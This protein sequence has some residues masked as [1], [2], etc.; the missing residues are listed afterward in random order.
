MANNVP[1][2][3]GGTHCHVANCSWLHL[4]NLTALK[5]VPPL[6]PNP[7]LSGIGVVLGFSIS[8][9]LTIA[10]LMLHYLTVHDFERTNSRGSQYINSI[11]RGILT[12]VRGRIISWKPSKRFEYAMEKSVLILSDLNLVTGLGLLIAA[13][14]QVRCGISA[15]HWQIMVFEAWFASFSFVSA[16]TFLDGYLQAN[17]NMRI[18]RVVSICILGTLLIV[19]LL[20][21]GSKTWLN[22]YPH[23]GEGFYPSL[24][25]A[26]FFKEL[27]MERFRHRS[28]KLWSMAFSI[29]VV[30]V[31]YVHCIFR[32]FEPTAGTPRKY[33]RQWPGTKVKHALY[34]LERKSASQSL[35]AYLWHVL[36]LIMYSMFIPA[37]AFYDIAES[38]LLEIIWLTFAMAWGTIKI[39]TTRYSATFNYDGRNLTENHEV[40][41]ENV[42]SFGQT[43]PL[44]LLLLPIL[45]MA[46]AY[47]DNDA[48][49]LETAYESQA[50]EP[51]N[52]SISLE[53]AS[54]HYE[55][56]SI[57]H[58]RLGPSSAPS[59]TTYNGNDHSSLQLLSVG[60]TTRQK[61]P[62]PHVSP[63]SPTC[64][65]AT[66]PMPQN[67]LVNLPTFPYPSFTS[68]PWYQDQI[69]LLL[70]QIFMVAGFALWVL[71]AWVNIFG[72]A[73]ILRNRIFLI[74]TLGIVPLASLAHLASWY[75]A[76]LVLG[77][78][79]TAQQ[80]LTGQRG[81]GTGERLVWRRR[82]TLGKV[83]YWL[84]RLG[85]VCGCLLGT[86]LASLDLAGPQ[87]LTLD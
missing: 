74:W 40:L 64:T 24:S 72:I 57:D 59:T 67:R 3:D 46:Q 43:L 84:L 82:V 23:D 34:F 80:W 39:W 21:T 27:T 30:V 50:V 9:Y 13:Y 42:W 19:A 8:A 60:N 78:W 52:G 87:D 79:Q 76:A 35:A 69:L 86:F 28:P 36:Y 32:L 41:E 38:M 45:S 47:L 56:Q 7:E 70:C 75:I 53:D 25:T 33:I 73:S 65:T 83:V 1:L 71:S 55:M 62:Q 26:C 2:E 15:Y 48:K 49:A 51:G 20:P 29:A 11:D 4:S 63:Q 10:L 22:Q 81:H 44:V 77:R 66:P 58:Q 17:R 12:F 85:L 5:H 54:T 18:I 6:H 31:S 37:R 16:M 61:S 14:S 68:K